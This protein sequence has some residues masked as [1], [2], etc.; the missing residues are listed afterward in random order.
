MEPANNVWAEHA[1]AIRHVEDLEA[2]A[3]S[4][5]EIKIRLLFESD[6][7]AAMQLKE[8]AGWNQ[9][10]DDWRR[11]LGSSRTVVLRR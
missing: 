7:P 9:T 5:S 8:A 10:E 11:L 1:T 6:I 2:I 4:E 3:I